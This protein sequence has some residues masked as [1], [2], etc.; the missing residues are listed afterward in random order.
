MSK[1]V[2]RLVFALFG[3]ISYLGSTAENPVTGETQRV[4]L[5]YEQEVILGQQGASEVANQFGGFYPDDQL[6]AYIDAVGQQVVQ[7]STASQLPY[8]YEFHLLGDAET[9][10]AFALPG[11]QIFIT[12]ALLARLNAEAQLAGV[13]GHEVAHVVARHGAEQIARQQF[14]ALLV[15]AFGIAASDNPDQGQQAAMIAQV[16]SQLINLSY[17]RED[18]LESDRL[19]FEFMVDAGYD[20]Q[21]IVE[22]MAILNAAQPDGQPPEFLS[23]HPNP[24][25]RI[26]RLQALIVQIF[27]DGVPPQLAMGESDFIQIVQPRLP[28][29]LEGAQ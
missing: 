3:L 16:V 2:I 9:V 19:G 4:Q 25:N 6:Q 18:E 22:L 23:S 15:Q 1:L 29:A 26:E 24:A 11:G 28:A 7:Q 17:G 21:G 13:L 20:P 10:N 27:P 12:L 8:P 5:S 14:G